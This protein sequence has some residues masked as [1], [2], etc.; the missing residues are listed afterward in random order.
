[1]ADLD[2]TVQGCQSIERQLISDRINSISQHILSQLNTASNA[3]IAAGQANMLHTDG[4]VNRVAQAIDTTVNRTAQDTNAAVERTASDGRAATERNGGDT[5]TALSDATSIVR[6]SIER[7]GGQTR[8][9]IQTS[10]SDLTRTTEGNASELRA[11]VNSTA[12][13]TQLAVEQAKSAALHQAGHNLAALLKEQLE[14]KYELSR[15]IAAEGTQTRQLI[16]KNQIDELREQLTVAK[17]ARFERGD[18]GERE[19]VNVRVVNSFDDD[20]HCCRRDSRE[21]GGSGNQT[22]VAG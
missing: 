1:M 2:S 15:Q 14:T 20:G 7:N 13:I 6:E 4:N 16:E 12:G 10:I 8:Q 19:S 11:L 17:L 5:R 3:V 18:R 9:Q 22:R 21:N